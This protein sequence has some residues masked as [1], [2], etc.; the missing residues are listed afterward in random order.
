MILHEISQQQYEI[1]F[2]EIY[3]ILAVVSDKILMIKK[4]KTCL[5]DKKTEQWTGRI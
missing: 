4:N 5:L 2:L 3:C 1:Q